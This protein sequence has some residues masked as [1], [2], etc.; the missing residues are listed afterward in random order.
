MKIL[1]TGGCGFLGSNIVQSL[2]LKNHDVTIIDDLS[3]GKQITDK[4]IN[5]HQ[6]SIDD[7][8]CEEIFKETSFDVVIHLAYRGYN[9]G[10]YEGNP[11]DIYI[12]NSG[13]NN[14]LFLSYKYGAKKVIGFS[15]FVS[16]NIIEE[17]SY[18]ARESLFD[19]YRRIGLNITLLKLAAVYGPGQ[20]GT[21]SHHIDAILK[22]ETLLDMEIKKEY[23]YIQDLCQAVT[24][25]VENDTGHSLRISSGIATSTKE[26]YKIYLKYMNNGSIEDG[27]MIGDENYGTM[28]NKA[29]FSLDWIPTITMEK[30]IRNTIDWYRKGSKEESTKKEEPLTKNNKIKLTQR[31]GKTLEII[32]LFIVLAGIHYIS[33]YKYGIKVDFLLLYIIFANLFYGFKEGFLALGMSVIALVWFKFNFEG[34]TVLMLT[35]DINMI[36]YL[37]MYGVIGVG[38]GYVIDTLREE[39]KYL[40]DEIDFYKGEMNFLKKLYDKST[41]VKN[42]LQSNIENYEDN[43]SKIYFIAEKLNKRS[44]NQILKETGEIYGNLLDFK[45]ISVYGLSGD[46]TWLR[47][48]SYLGEPK[49]GSLI[50]INKYGFLSSTI[51]EES[52]YI[53]RELE[54]EYP[55]ICIPI[56]Y[57]DE[58]R[59]LVFLDNIDFNKLTQKNLNLLK[60]VTKFITNGLS[61]AFEY[62]KTLAEKM[63]GE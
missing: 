51:K 44:T 9:M 10:T 61:M 21:D 5:F 34:R 8:R 17:E 39:K 23:I 31:V 12:N 37:T 29:I 57:G 48:T 7:K 6:L 1:I 40:L 33:Q 46:R 63:G 14:I 38:V 30:G 53:N 4:G 36:L 50:N 3:T 27:E 59:A 11:N 49:Y 54:K 13:L 35:N 15:S 19:E 28:A 2:N 62:E 42:R 32:I 22:E 47:L 25:V 24:A 55:T 58:V 56:V 41:E 52:W 43:Y 20:Y 45:N 18:L 16:S 60:V 26:I